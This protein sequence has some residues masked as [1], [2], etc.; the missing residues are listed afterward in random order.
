MAGAQWIITFE[1]LV[2]CVNF[3]E[4]IIFICRINSAA[5]PPP[6]SGPMLVPYSA[7]N[8]LQIRLQPQLPAARREDQNLEQKPFISDSRHFNSYHGYKPVNPAFYGSYNPIDNAY[9]L[10]KPNFHHDYNEN[11]I[12][13]NRYVSKDPN[14]SGFKPSRHDPYFIPSH[15]PLKFKENEIDAFYQRSKRHRNKNKNFDPYGNAKRKRKESKKDRQK[16]RR[17]PEPDFGLDQPVQ[18]EYGFSNSHERSEE[19][20][21]DRPTRDYYYKYY[22]NK[23]KQSQRPFKPLPTQPIKINLTPGPYFDNDINSR[24]REEAEKDLYFKNLL[25][26][27]ED[28]ENKDIFEFDQVR[29]RP[30]YDSTEDKS[31]SEEKMFK[32]EFFRD[33]S[34]ERLVDKYLSNLNSDK[35]IFE[36]DDSSENMSDKNKYRYLTRE[37][38]FRHNNDDHSSSEEQSS[39]FQK[40]RNN[41]D[42]DKFNLRENSEEQNFGQSSEEENSAEIS[43]FKFIVQDKLQGDC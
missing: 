30:P 19:I 5:L 40:L 3:Q 24:E 41:H 43:Q 23:E 8:H 36:T 10:P 14:F 21:V 22:K 33:S 16:F 29:H 42:K 38:G 35:N 11:E 37:V 1:R 13:F 9:Y 26:I 27:E 6:P 4:N 12:G 25:E 2:I 39:M 20:E 32:N 28:H 34:E 17:L 18:D 15:N 7:G 31:S